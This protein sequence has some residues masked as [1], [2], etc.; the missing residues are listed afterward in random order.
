M[1]KCEFAGT[2]KCCREQHQETVAERTAAIDVTLGKRTK[3]ISPFIRE[4]TRLSEVGTWSTSL[5]PSQEL[6][7]LWAQFQ[8]LGE[9]MDTDAF[10]RVQTLMEGDT[11]YS[12]TR[13]DCPFR[14]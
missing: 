2:G 13:Q 12:G 8:Q 10:A 1:K 4:K 9:K 11:V 5:R 14:Q 7:N 3:K 6:I